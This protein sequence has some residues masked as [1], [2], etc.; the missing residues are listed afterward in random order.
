MT[1][2]GFRSSHCIC[3]MSELPSVTETHSALEQK[4]H[5]SIHC[6]V[7]LNAEFDVLIHCIKEAEFKCDNLAYE[8]K[9]LEQLG[10][11]AKLIDQKK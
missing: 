4:I 8:I 2:F 3:A 5:K 7:K 1:I 9:E 6:V 10:K 11:E